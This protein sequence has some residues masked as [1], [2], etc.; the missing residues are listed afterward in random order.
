MPKA[1]ANE[2]CIQEALLVAI[3]IM[4]VAY[5][6][7]SPASLFDGYWRTEEGRLFGIKTTGGRRVLVTGISADAQHG[8]LRPARRICV[9]DECGTLSLDRRTISWPTLGIWYR[10]GVF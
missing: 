10:Q 1:T 8:R 7:Y 9:G 6:I 4:V 3:C 2:C 5:F